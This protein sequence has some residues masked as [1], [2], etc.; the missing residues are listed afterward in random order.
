MTQD[1]EIIRPV[2]TL[3]NVGAM[4]PVDKRSENKRKQQRPK[5]RRGPVPEQ[6][7]WP[8][9]NMPADN[10]RTEPGSIDYRA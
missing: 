6:A 2:E 9:E 10:G 7:G 8:D 4:T 3:Q 1:N 5:P